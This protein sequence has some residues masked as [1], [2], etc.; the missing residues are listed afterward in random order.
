ML[1]ASVQSHSSKVNKSV[2]LTWNG[3]RFNIGLGCAQL[4]QQLLIETRTARQ[5]GLAQAFADQRVQHDI[6]TRIFL[7]QPFHDF[8]ISLRIYATLVL[9]KYISY[10]P[11]LLLR[12]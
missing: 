10:Q 11:F 7:R 9:V 8:R 3:F 5:F 4:A 1:D 6:Q 2:T 12:H